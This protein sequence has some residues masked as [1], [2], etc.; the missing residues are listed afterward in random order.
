MT[1][2][3]YAMRNSKRTEGVTYN[4]NTQ[5]NCPTL[6]RE[7]KALSLSGGYGGKTSERE[8][9]TWTLR[10]DLKKMTH[11]IMAETKVT[12]ILIM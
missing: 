12:K 2:G 1:T 10:P 9:H 11:L 6:T 4:I 7:L 3:R 8:S 5:M